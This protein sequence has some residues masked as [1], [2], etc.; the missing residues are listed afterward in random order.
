MQ[1]RRD[2]NSAYPYSSSLRGMA[3]IMMQKDGIGIVVIN[4]HDRRMQH[5]VIIACETIISCMPHQV[6]IGSRYRVS[7]SRCDNRRATILLAIELP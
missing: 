4:R 2:W 1:I 6:V 5:R 7:N 3:A